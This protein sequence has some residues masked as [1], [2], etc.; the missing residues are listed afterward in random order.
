[1]LGDPGPRLLL[2]LTVLSLGTAVPS[3]GASKSKRQAQQVIQPQSPLAVSQSKPGC[4]DNGK[5][6]QI[7]QQWERTYL[8]SALVCTCY[9]G[10]RGFNC[11]SKPEPEETCFDK[12]TGNTYRV[13]DTYERPKDSMIWDC[14]C[15]GAGRGRISCTIANRCHEGGQSYKIGDTWRRPHE[16]GGYMLECVCLGNGKG[17]WTC[18][19]IAEKCFDHAAGTSYVVGET[20]EKPYQGWM[21]VDCTCLGE[22]S[23]RIT[24]TSRNR[25]NDQDTRTSYRIGDTWRKKDNR[26]NLLQCIC[27]GN[28][29]GEWKCERHTTLQTTSAGSGSFTD[30]RTA[31]YQ[32]QPHPQPAPYGHCVTDSGVVYSVGMQWLKAQGN[33]QMLCTC[34]GNG[35]SCQETAITQTYGGNSNGE[36]CVLPF[37]YNGRTFY[38]CTTEGRQDGHLW[39]STTSNYEQDQKYSFCTDHTVLVQTRGGNSNG[40]LCHF[41]FLY[42][43][44][45][46]TDCTSEGRRDNMKWCGTTRNY[47]ADQKFGFCPMA[48]HEEICTTNEGIMYRIGDQW[49]KQHDMGHMMRCTCV[50]NGRGEWT[51]VA[52]SQLRDQCIVDDIT[53]N[54]NDT[55]HKRHEEGHMLNCTCFG[56]GRGRWKCDPIDQCQDSE[57]RTF[58]QIGESW[59]KFLHGVRYQCYC[60]GR[61]I[62]EWGCQPIQTYPG[63]T[64]P[65]QVIITE[66]PSQPNSHPIQW[67]APEPSHISKYI[68]RWKPKN[69]PDRWKEATIPGHLNSYTIKGLRPGVVYEGQLISVQHYGQR[70][71]TRFDFT[72]TSTSPVVTSNT[73]TGETT[74]FSP[75]VA[76]SESVTEITA[77]SFVVSWVSAS[78]TVSGFRVE[79]EL[80]EEGDEPQYLDLPSTATSVNIPDLLP[81]RKYIVNVYQISEEG[82]QSLILSTSQTTAPDAPPDPTV[83]QVDNTS[84]VVRW[85]R[86]Q[87]PITGYRIVYSP[88]VE[89][90][91]TELNLPE[92]ANSV[93]LSDLQPG[94][95]Y[96]ITIYAVEE[97]QESTPVFIQQETTGVPRSDKVPPP[98]D[99]QFVEVTDVKITIMWTPP[100]SAVTGYRVDV[101]PVNLPG[102]HGQRLPISR[103]TFAEVTG[104]SPGVTYHFKVFAVN[105]GRESKPLTAQQATKLDAPT[106]LQ[107]INETDTT[108]IVTWTPPRAR[109]AGYRLT[110]GLTRGGQP[111]QYNVGPSS[112]QYPLRN[113][114]PGSEYSATLVAVKGSQQSPRVTGV[115]TTLQPLSSIPP[116]HT[117]VTETTIVI[118]W[119]PAPRIGFKLGVRP[120]QGGEAPREVTSESGSIVVSGLTP[121]VEYIYT[122][123]VLKDG[124]ERDTPIVKKVV[125]PLSPPKNLHLE[126]NP[127]TGVLTVSW[128][129]SNT[130]D[131]TG[132]RITTTPT[133][134][135]QGY[136]LEEVVHADQSSCTFENLSPGLEYNVSVYTVKDDKESVPI[137]DTIMPEVPQLT[138]LSFVDITDSS[139]GLRWTPLNSSTII[140]YRI[141]VVA[142]GEGIPIFEDFVDSSVGYYTVTGLEPGIDYDIS[143]ITLIN[144]G[145]SAPTTLTQQ[146][147]VPPPTDLRFTNVGPD[148]MRVTWAP[149]PSIELTNLLVR[150]SPVKNEEDVAELSVSPSDNAVFL[151]NLLPGTEYLVSVSSVYEQHESVPLRGR[152]KTGLDSPTGI[153]FSDITANSFTVHWIAP[154][155]TITG[156]KI[157]HHP[158]HMGGRHREDRVP[159]SR[160]SITLT[161]LNPGTDYVVT[162][163][164]L[165]GKEESPSLVGQQTTVS[166]VP[167]DLEV[168]AATPTSLLIS[169][170]APAVTVRYYR[171]TYGET[172][173]NSPVQEFTVPGSKSTATISGL[174]PGADY[175]ITVYAVTGRG[176]SPASSKP[177][178]IDYRTEIDKPSQMQVTDVQDNS[179]SVRWLPSS[180]PVTGYRVTTTPKNGPGPSKTMTAGPDQTEMTI[181]GL[182]PTVEYVVSVYA[183]N[184]NG[185]SQPLVQTAVTNIDRPKGLAFTDVDVDSIKIAW[186]S[187][188]GQ[189]SRYRVTYSSPED[190]IHELFPAPDG[191]EETAELQ[192]LRP[193]SEYTVSVV[194]LHDDMESQ[195]L[196]GTQ[197][198]AIPAPTN[199]KFTQVSPTSL[200]AQ[201]TAPNVQLT[202]YRVRVTP[203]EKTGPMKEINLAPDSSSVV[204]SGLMVATKYE[205]SVYALK[206]T[207]TSRPA[208]G[209]VTTLENVSPPR[210][211]RV[212]DATETTITISWRTK[213]ETITGFQ[214]DAI[215]ANGQTPIQR[216]IKPDVRSYTITGLQPGTDY[217]IHLYT[218]NDNAR[219]SPVVID[220]STAIDA[221]SNLHFLATTPNSLLLSWQPPRARITGY[222]IKYE[223]PGSPPREVV[224]RPRPGVTEATITG[225]EP[226]IE[227]TIQVIALKNNQKSEPL[228]GRKKTD[229]LPQLV[230]LP[231]PNLHGP[232]ILDVPSTVQKTPFITN[233]GYDTGNGI[234]LPGTSGQQPSLGQQMIFEE[235]GFRRTTPP[236]MASPVRHRPRPYPPNVNEEIQIGPVPRGDVDHHLYPHVLGLNPNASTG[237]EAL[238]QTTISW[239]PFQESSEYIISC[240]PVGIDEEPLQ[241][242]V[243]GTSASATLTGLTRGATYNII[244]EAIKD[245]KRHKVREQ[246]VTVGNSADQGLNQPTD[247]SCFDPYTVSHYAIGE[248]WERLSESGFKLSC[249]CL[250]FGSG[251]FRCDSSKWC[252]DNGVNYKIGEKW[253]RQGESGQMMSCTCLGNGKGEFKCDPHEATCYDDGK[254]YHVGEQW[255]K[256]YLG[257]ICS[258]TC[259]GGQRGW[260]CDNCRRPGAE[261]GHEGSTGHSYNQY[262]QRYHQRTN[263]NVN[264]P[265]E[266]FMPLDVQA[267][268]EDS[269]E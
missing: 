194:A 120:S 98:R 175:T 234:Q 254:T 63:S 5:H 108:I 207:L 186:E 10:S 8:G 2:L 253:D 118:T 263:T 208:Q 46:Y 190:G 223:K 9:G 242:R 129:R 173:G 266:C 224:P 90:S 217:K 20:W 103:N 16:T 209:V 144:G 147:A 197:S 260:R 162:I 229:E 94:V 81:G 77:S 75:V 258:C 178:S 230:T 196:I 171:I 244:V 177:I 50:G 52:Y 102:E 116:Y 203:K 135:Q 239:T 61:G 7:N 74:P 168:I 145:E 141:T 180:S 43:N 82:E 31:I 132:Y 174:K 6:Y 262:S 24:C 14:T 45:N 213:T 257:A 205:V 227:Y 55:F 267:D 211:A 69:S 216:T 210:R 33:K 256:E 149:P 240:H 140:G 248:E 125:T 232:E 158:E 169:W 26:G 199:L 160:N 48:A 191:E 198:T 54:V 130:P 159:P 231:H 65:V 117:E 95:Q 49:D 176:D 28:G 21:M 56:Q 127:D 64:G 35:V 188:Q 268:R 85:S 106:N 58:Y 109:I 252:H 136:S 107:F 104:L 27:T 259:F 60:Y 128:E 264:C 100:E 59:E 193:G 92:T 67:N 115:F 88:S 19:P 119:T 126:T 165:N 113:L 235:H 78:D 225:L 11:E 251:H 53:Y 265:I 243:P 187:P 185:E 62:G 269:R 152:Q 23:G 39:C 47:D 241:F 30:V 121:G 41:P 139:I 206:D 164:A 221:P 38:S 42:N 153:D 89:G 36:P 57:S 4:Y 96:N 195:P 138:D 83:D 228:I 1:M 71:M 189:V 15:I 13:G 222:I 237:Q 134:G 245:Q 44:Q 219:S 201:W 247:D 218:L 166:D 184:R 114:Q 66:T 181:E 93:T 167:R 99:L 249:Q 151:T 32:P 105:H 155:A 150:Y 87:A 255:Q 183:Q 70:E 212:T 172:G 123:S 124:Q 170:D 202:G 40:A 137:S 192:G 146:T 68:L 131:I 76:T 86:P 163:V 34:L 236:T 143:V 233:P 238:S 79:Y 214:V 112:T 133:N 261:P 154:R 25:C 204:V 29:R 250:G 37:T 148:T 97:N 156:Y 80:S 161:N 157:R 3:T 18:K 111:K 182:Q 215:P 17:E 22:G 220:A 122:I 72:T 91:S 110:V 200:A 226:G 101:I 246:V 51:C 142:A 73:V 179:I 84:I 12:Y